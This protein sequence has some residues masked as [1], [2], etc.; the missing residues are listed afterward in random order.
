MLASWALQFADFFDVPGLVAYKVV[1]YIKEFATSLFGSP[2]SIYFIGDHSKARLFNL[3]H[4]VT[5]AALCWLSKYERIDVQNIHLCIVTFPW[6]SLVTILK[7]TFCSI[8]AY[9]FCFI[10]FIFNRPISNFYDV[11]SPRFENEGGHDK[12]W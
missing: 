7:V 9:G 11:I 10:F 1:A 2:A 4:S 6:F 3:A 5:P 12:I 8:Q